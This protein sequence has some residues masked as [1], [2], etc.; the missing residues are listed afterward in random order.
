MKKS[1]RRKKD[2]DYILKVDLVRFMSRF[3]PSSEFDWKCVK[4]CQFVASFKIQKK[5]GII[6]MFRY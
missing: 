4:V 3:V 2:I 5:I 6:C 1:A